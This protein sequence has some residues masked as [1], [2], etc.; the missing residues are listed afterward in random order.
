MSNKKTFT[1]KEFDTIISGAKSS[2]EDKY[3]ILEDKVFSELK[4]FIEDFT[5]N[6]QNEIE[7]IFTFFKLGY[8]PSVKHTITINNYVG[9]IELPSGYQI[10]VLPKIDFVEEDAN[11]IVTKKIFLNMLKSLKE[12][13]SKSFSLASLD[14]QKMDLYEIFISMFIKEASD[15]VRKGL[16]SNYVTTEDNL[17]FYKGK[18]NISKHIKHNLSHKE[19]FYMR[20]DEYSLNR[21]ENKIIKAT[22]LYLL[23]KS[24]NLDNQ[25]EIKRLLIYF[26]EVDA[27]TDYDKDFSNIVFDR[28]NEIYKRLIS[29]ARIFLKNKSFATFSG[30]STGTA[31][32]FP[33]ETVFEEYVAEKIK[34]AFGINGWK[35]STQDKTYHLFE[36]PRQRFL[37]KPDI[38]IE[39]DNKYIVLDTKWKKLI[40][41]PQQNYGISQ[42]D[43]YQM[44]AY[45]NKYVSNNKK[46]Q[47]ILLYPKNTEINNVNIEPYKDNQG[48]EVRTY[49][50]DLRKEQIDSNLLDLLNLVEEINNE[51]S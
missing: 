36:Q 49:F 38:V 51:N 25:K 43:M 48:V 18:M 32:L 47:V 14:T 29:W 10:E 45:S 22:L 34:Q 50:I 28:T 39:K 6:N 26:D 31:L 8:K 5:Q 35:V 30:V 11:Y 21:P 41:N 12:F 15:V 2:K 7:N 17:T 13:Q 20:F 4:V 44:Y 23:R 24:T 3:Y 16:K 42:S 33:M 1:V 37:I 46:A 9:I 27:S 19:R 40:N